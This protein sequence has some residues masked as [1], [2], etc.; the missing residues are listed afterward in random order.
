M[1]EEKGITLIS[2]IT[3]VILITFAVAGVAAITNSLYSNVNNLDRDAKSTVDFAKFNMYFIKDIKNDNVKLVSCSN[4]QILLSVT[5]NSGNTENISYSLQHGGLY[6]NSVKIC[7]NVKA[8]EISQ[9]SDKNEISIYLK[10]DNYA[11][12]ITYVLEPDKIKN[13][14]INV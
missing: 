5:D 2:L 11:K 1:K 9:G 13:Q 14:D 10:I 3:Y 6:R 4:N 7:D 8:V 12:T